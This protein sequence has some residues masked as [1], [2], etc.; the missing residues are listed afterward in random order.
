MFLFALLLSEPILLLLLSEHVFGVLFC[1][2]VVMRAC[3]ILLL[4][5]REPVVSVL[6]TYCSYLAVPGTVRTYIVQRGEAAPV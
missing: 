2:A 5:L 3:S 6:T 4:L 1:R